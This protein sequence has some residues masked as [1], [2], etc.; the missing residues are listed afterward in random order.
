MRQAILQRDIIVLGV[1]YNTL[2]MFLVSSINKS[3][4]HDVTEILLKVVL[5]TIN[6][7][8]QINLTK[9]QGNDRDATTHAITN[10]MINYLR[11]YVTILTWK[12][13]Q[14]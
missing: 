7:P 4:C 12:N 6:Q 1:S 3:D 8:N 11:E 5:N 13:T 14:I 10:F 2:P 9:V